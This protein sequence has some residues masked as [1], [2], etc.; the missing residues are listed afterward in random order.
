M[1]SIT[2]TPRTTPSYLSA[3]STNL[4][5]INIPPMRP[6]YLISN[7]PTSQQQPTYQNLGPQVPRK[8][9]LYGAGQR[10]YNNFKKFQIGTT[11]TFNGY[12][13]ITGIP[14][15]II[16]PRPAPRHHLPPPPPPRY[17]HNHHYPRHYK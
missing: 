16:P 13:S 10:K 11:T 17:H 9:S 12:T 8:P 14:P 15:A 4:P 3:T 1:S 2:I 6:L 7:R 5:N